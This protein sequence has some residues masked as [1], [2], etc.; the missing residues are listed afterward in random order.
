MTK[1][2]QT[3]WPF[4]VA[5]LLIVGCA[6]P[7]SAAD[8]DP[9]KVSKAIER[10]VIY[11]KGKQKADGSWEGYPNE[12]GS[13]EPSG[14]TSLCVIAL[15]SAGV[16]KDD[17]AIVRALQYLRGIRF[18]GGNYHNY[19][20]SLQTMAMALCDPERDLPLIRNNVRWLEE[21]QLQKGSSSGGWSY[22]P[23]QTNSDNSNA[24][25]SIL[26]L[27]EAERV[28]VSAKHETWQRAKKYW[29]QT[30]NQ[31]GSW[32]YTPTGDKGSSGDTGSMTCAGIASLVITSGMTGQG[33]AVVRGDRIIC[34]TPGADPDQ[35]RIQ[36]GLTFLANHFSVDNNPNMGQTYLYYYL[37]GLE[38]VG[39]MTAQRFIG[40]HDWYREGTDFLLQRKGELGVYWSDT[41]QSTLMPTSFAIIFLSRGRWPILVSKIQ[42]GDD[43]S[44]NMHANDVDHLTRYVES[45]WKNE[46]TWQVI[47][48]SPATSEDLMQ[49][50][51][52]YLSGNR[53]PLPKTDREMESTVR[54]L[55]DYLDHGGFIFAE[56]QPNDESFATGFRELIRRVL[57][58]EGY[59]LRLLDVTHPIWHAEVEIEPDQIRP[60]EGI[61]FGCRTSVVFCPAEKQ[62][63]GNRPSLSCLWEVA[64]AYERDEPY[65]AGVQ[66]Q[67]DAGLD[68]GINILA[69][70]TNREMK[71]KDQKMLETVGMALAGVNQRRGRVY[72]GL[73]E[74]GGGA[75][76]APRAVPNML[77]WAEVSLGIPVDIRVDRVSMVDP[78]VFD[79]PILFMHG[80]GTFT[81]SAEERERFGNFIG[82][83][84]TLFAN[85]IC[86][87]PPFV[88]AFKREMQQIFPES[89][90]VRIPN[91][92]PLFSDQYGGFTIERLRVQTPRLSP[93]RQMQLAPQEQVPELYGIKVD[94]RWAVVFSP[95]DVSCALEKT[96][97][98]DC[99]GYHPES[100]LRLAVNVLMYAMD[101]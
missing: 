13:S 10:G 88:D 54:K 38:R 19:A 56:A 36:N 25:F 28:G 45:R 83:G 29:E 17:P 6:V 64:K 84:G 73:L 101:R 60:I 94:D 1:T 48:L 8:I 72:L 68:I 74:Q 58:E 93:G 35:N 57:P 52:L 78:S 92:D 31:R 30:Q 21:L 24:Q 44:W 90:F 89:P 40:K 91:D 55:R 39:R 70:A 26:A 80:R 18:G 63:D 37:Y 79:Y 22:T 27:Y 32:G 65:P 3:R 85:A 59:E 9:E 16:P 14:L 75:N 33:G 15:R 66:R 87:S 61:N 34:H 43:K 47:N 23:K 86:S 95:L 99:K 41:S 81:F 62:G 46:L 53:S 4:L 7:L 71:T 50:P 97:T 69:Y 20:A 5:L 96:S 76:S 98:L 42:Y 49:S 11:L 2:K 12:S 100:A 51:V 67:I 82:N 77:Q